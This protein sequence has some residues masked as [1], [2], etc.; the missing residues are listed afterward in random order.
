[1]RKFKLYDFTDDEL[2]TIRDRMDTERA[3]LSGML[4]IQSMPLGT[5][6]LEMLR[7][8]ISALKDEQPD[9]KLIVVDSG[10]HI[11]PSRHY[12]QKRH[13]HTEAFEG[14]KNIAET[15]EVVIWSSVH[16]SKEWA[17]RIGTA[18]AVGED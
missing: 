4:R 11:V 7:A 10:D 8:R 16:A 12:E 6:T 17:G 15:E 2:E 1:Y 13:A 5:C 3:R 9:L 18:E 14:L